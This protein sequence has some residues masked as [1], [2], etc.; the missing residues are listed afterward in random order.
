M[1]SPAFVQGTQRQVAIAPA[2]HPD[3]KVQFLIDDTSYSKGGTTIGRSIALGD[4]VD[5]GPYS[6]WRQDDWSGGI[7]QDKWKDPTQCFFSDADGTTTP[8]LLKPNAGWLQI[9]YLNSKAVTSFRLVTGS[10]GQL[11]AG[12][13]NTFGRTSPPVTSYNLYKHDPTLGASVIVKSALTS[14]LNALCRH[15][16][17]ATTFNYIAVGFANGDIG[18]LRE[19]TNAWTLEASGVAPN[20]VAHGG[21]EYDSMCQY[22]DAL[23]FCAGNKL[24]KRTVAAGPVVTYAAVRQVLDAITLRGLVVWNGKL[25]FTA[26]GGS[27]QSTLWQCD[28]TTATPVLRIPGDFQTWSMCVHRGS[29]YIG[30]SKAVGDPESA[31]T[32]QMGQLWQYTGSSLELVYEVGGLDY[33]D[34][35]IYAVCSY[36]QY[37]A[38]NKNG[39][40]YQY[41]ATYNTTYPSICGVYLYDPS[42]DSI[43]IGPSFG[44]FSTTTLICNSLCWYNDSLAG[45]FWDSG[46][47]TANN[48]GPLM[49][50]M[51][52]KQLR[53]GIHTGAVFFGESYDSATINTYKKLYSSDYDAGLAENKVWM[54]ARVQCR[55]PSPNT[56]IEVWVLLD[57]AKPETTEKFVG[58]ITYDSSQTDWRSVSFPL[59]AGGE[60]FS[61][62]SLRYVLKFNCPIDTVAN[63]TAV[64]AVEIAYVV[65]PKHRRSWRFRVVA[66]DDQTL[67]DG[68]ANPLTTA[69]AIR[70]AIEAFW[71]TPVLFWEANTDGVASGTGVQC[72]VTDFGENSFVVD[73]GTNSTGGYTQVSLL[74]L[75]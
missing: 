40:E 10:S 65:A 50:G 72:Y 8:G 26:I 51:T 64:R 74:E 60:Y 52:R 15:N 62:K 70:S 6:V 19:D 49:I 32:G 18:F 37:V 67:L 34:N 73:S 57:G 14:G 48:N 11:Y 35:G 30:G 4:K 16:D 45:S 29:L 9:G 25:W 5:L 27:G 46:L 54:E 36:G 3:Q 58:T 66:S 69:A 41:R 47:V 22:N 33:K 44:A 56:S 59:R 24:M 53:T 71:A 13:T 1:T 68:T 63:N 20:N 39:T 23:W 38:F 55:L 61:S 21:V 75:I 2:G 7:G 43:H 12:E 42:T 28:G 31:L 17:I